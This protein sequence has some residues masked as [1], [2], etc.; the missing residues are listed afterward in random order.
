MAMTAATRRCKCCDAATE[1]FAS[2]DFSRSCEDRNGPPFP[3]SGE[4]VP[5]VRCLSCGFI[6]TDYFDDWSAAQMADRI[7]NADYYLADPDFAEKRPAGTAADLVKWLGG[8]RSDIAALDYGGGNGT[9]AAVMRENGFD[10]DSYDPYFAGDTLPTRRYDLVTS[11]EVVEHTPDPLGNLAALLAL[12]KPDGAVLISTGLQPRQ[13]TSDWWYIAPRNGHISIHSHLSLQHLARK[14]AVRVL[15]IDTTHLLFRRA[16]D[17]VARAL[18]RRDVFSL[19]WHASRQNARALAMASLTAAQVG[20][21]I[22]ALDPRHAA[23]LLLGEMRS[24][25]VGER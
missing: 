11:F 18:L 6:F 13:V 7:Y 10:Y 4:L 12:V 3:P 15:T 1:P 22:A 5:Y 16:R 20:R 23:R 2:L 8:L 25:R 24:S 14:L 21:P 9:L 19:L 17:P